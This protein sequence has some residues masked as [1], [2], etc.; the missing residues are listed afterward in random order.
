MFYKLSV[1]FT[2]NYVL[3]PMLVYAR[4]RDEWYETGKVVQQARG[5][6]SRSQ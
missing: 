5:Q 1:G 6:R 4:K 2:I 3:M